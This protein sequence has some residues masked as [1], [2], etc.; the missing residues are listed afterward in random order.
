MFP[1]RDFTRIWWAQSVSTLGSYV[2]SLALSAIVVLTLDGTAQE[3]G[4]LNSARWL[5][6]LVLGLVVGAL[7]DRARRRPVM[8]ITDLTR[9]VLLCLIPLAWGLDLL[10]FALLLVFVILFGT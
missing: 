9:A 7:V 10:T 4:W 1:T 5:P 3:V 2:T 8:I 6:Y